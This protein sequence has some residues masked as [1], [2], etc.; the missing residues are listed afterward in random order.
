VPRI[1]DSKIDIES[2]TLKVIKFCKKQ[3]TS[4]LDDEKIGWNYINFPRFPQPGNIDIWTILLC[5]Q[6]DI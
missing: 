1:P 2:I 5:S 6:M 3:K 4:K